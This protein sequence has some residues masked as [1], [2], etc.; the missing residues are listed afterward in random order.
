MKQLFRSLTFWLGLPGL[1]FLLWAWWD[2]SKFDSDA[3]MYS[4]G[5]LARNGDS[6]FTITILE[7]Y[8]SYWMLSGSLGFDRQPR[9]ESRLFFP[10]ARIDR[11]TEPHW[12]R[13]FIPHW[14]VVLAYAIPWSVL[15]LWSRRRI[16]LRAVMLEARE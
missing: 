12:T 7:D 10:S 3:L 15:F 4:W 16:R 11:M 8:K 2:S 1:L 13:I 5:F 6:Q 9:A 14:Q